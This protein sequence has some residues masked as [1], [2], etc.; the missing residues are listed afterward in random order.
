MRLPEAP[1]PKCCFE[2]ILMAKER[3]H[4]QVPAKSDLRAGGRTK[5]ATA[6]VERLLTAYWA[7]PELRQ[8]AL[9]ALLSY[10]YLHPL[11]SELVDEIDSIADASPE[12]SG[13]GFFLVALASPRRCNNRLGRLRC[14]FLKCRHVRGCRSPL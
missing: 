7:E 4:R 13:D 9:V 14:Q 3:P 8:G 12:S 5:G 1:Q 11:P 6:A 10:R 2:Q